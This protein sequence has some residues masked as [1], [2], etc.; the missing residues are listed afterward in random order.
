MASRGLEH[1]DALN[2]QERTCTA[3]S[4][5]Q[6][7]EEQSAEIARLRR[8]IDGMAHESTCAVFNL[9]ITVC[10][11][12]GV[13]LIFADDDELCETRQLHIWKTTPRGECSCSKSKA[14][15]A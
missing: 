14:V 9:E 10:S 13:G 3:P 2:Q 1:W 12:C 8:P 7:I 6:V 11:V 4:L 5:Y 15:K